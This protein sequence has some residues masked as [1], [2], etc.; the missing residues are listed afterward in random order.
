MNDLE[1][2]WNKI[3]AFLG[4]AEKTVEDKAY[5]RAGKEAAAI[6]TQANPRNDSTFSLLRYEARSSTDLEEEA[7]YVYR[8]ISNLQ[9]NRLS[10]GKGGEIRH[11]LLPSV[12]LR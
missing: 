12:L 1:L 10:E 7:S 3:H 6:F 2:N 11:I 5:F 8:K 9:N 4:E